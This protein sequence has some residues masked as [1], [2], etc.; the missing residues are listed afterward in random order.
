MMENL[1]VILRDQVFDDLYLSKRY[2]LG[3]SVP[4]RMRVPV[5]M[6]CKGVI[7]L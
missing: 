4:V 5:N 1:D 2:C 6:V 3:V 7:S